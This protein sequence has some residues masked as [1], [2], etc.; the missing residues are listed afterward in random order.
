MVLI[1]IFVRAQKLGPRTTSSAYDVTQWWS[2]TDWYDVGYSESEVDYLIDYSYELDSIDLDQVGDI[3]K[4]PNRGWLLLEKLATMV[5]TT[6]QNIK[7]LV[8]KMELLD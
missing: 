7:Q 8:E 2:Y 4:I 5:R 1:R 3:V 6:Q